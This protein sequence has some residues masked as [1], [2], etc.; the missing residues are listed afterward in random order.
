MSSAADVDLVLP[1]S[2]PDEDIV[3]S[4]NVANNCSSIVTRL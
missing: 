3:L 4:A 1:P 2:V